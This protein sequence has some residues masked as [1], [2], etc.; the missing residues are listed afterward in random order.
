MSI[1]LLIVSVLIFAV[2]VDLLLVFFAAKKLTMNTA[3]PYL[4][5]ALSVTLYTLGYAVRLWGTTPEQVYGGI[6]IVYLGAVSLAPF[7]VILA[8]SYSGYDKLIGRST[9]A[10]LFIIPLITLILVNTNQ[11]HHLFYRHIEYRVEGPFYQAVLH[12]GPWHAV[13]VF[14]NTLAMVGGTSV[15]LIMAFR[16]SGA[17]RKQ[18]LLMFLCSMERLCTVSRRTQLLWSG[19]HALPLIHRP[20]SVRGVLVPLQTF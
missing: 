2:V 13:H 1:K 19:L 10:L 14:Y 17:Y 6:R 15:Y 5:V 8:L 16:T 4:L 20:A 12:R 9:Y 7:W 3:W 18:A 11:Y